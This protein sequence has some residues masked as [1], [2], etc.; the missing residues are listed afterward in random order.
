MVVNK[1]CTN[2]EQY[3]KLQAEFLS[4]LRIFAGLQDTFLDLNKRVRRLENE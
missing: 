2:I 1:D 3:T 4:L